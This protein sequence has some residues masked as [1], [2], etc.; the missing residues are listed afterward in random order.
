M[1]VDPT[2]RTSTST[3]TGTATRT[4]TITSFTHGG[5]TRRAG[6]RLAIIGSR[7]WR[8]LRRRAR[9]MRGWLGETVTP[10]GWIAVAAALLG[11]V[12][13]LSLAIVEWLAVG[14]AALVLLLIGGLFLLGGNA[15]EVDLGVLA[16]HVVAG[17]E[18]AGDITVRNASRH[19]VLPGRLEIPIGAA[20]ADTLVPLLAPGAVHRER[21]LIPAQ[22]RGI[23]DVGPVRSVREDPIGLLHRDITW[24]KRHTLYVHPRTVGL[25][26]T[27]T[28]LTRD[29]EGIPSRVLVDDDISFHAIR[30]YV[31]GDSP[32]NIHWKSTAKTGALMVRQYE[33]TRR[34]RV[35]VLLS[36]AAEEY[37]E[38]DEFELAVSAA[39]SIGVRL[40][41]DRREPQVVVSG[42][43][44]EGARRVVRAVRRL[45]TATPVLLLD[46]FSGVDR[47]PLMMGLAEITALTARQLPDLSLV[48]VVCGSVPTLRDLREATRR[49]DP[50]T[51]VVVV[52]ADPTARPGV[53]R[54]DDV[55]VLTLGAIDDLR[56]LMSRVVQ[57]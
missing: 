43:V 2:T 23:I 13:G 18:V 3:S 31:P 20:V 29:L 7:T 22:R 36:L 16:D 24:A 25:P 12:L 26:T 28:G 4:E 41:R 19:P 11:V 46:D 33:E 17:E 5:A 48:F 51:T 10:A 55:L 6:A 42:E 21:L 53:R 1:P 9:R 30:E 52:C 8:R 40:V 44:P 27:A 49:L 37:A 47:T 15:Y 32:R 54:V 56:H 39:A 45:A 34:S 38:D 35:G 50:G 14:L 57:A